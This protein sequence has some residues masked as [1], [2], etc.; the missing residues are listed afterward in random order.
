M[1]VFCGNPVFG[2]WTGT[3]IPIRKSLLSLLR[4][5][6]ALASG[7]RI[8]AFGLSSG[9]GPSAFGLSL[10]RLAKI[11]KQVLDVFYADRDSHETGTDACFAARFG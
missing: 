10:Q 3:H 8:S 1:L 4:L 11:F 6:A 2:V 9:F 5:F 7:F